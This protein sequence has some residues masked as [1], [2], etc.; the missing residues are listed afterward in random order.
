[1]G[2][3]MVQFDTFMVISYLLSMCCDQQYA[4]IHKLNC[5]LNKKL[6]NRPTLRPM[7]YANIGAQNAFHI[8]EFHNMLKAREYRVGDGAIR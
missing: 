5:Q 1:M 3:V 8:Y 4:T 2:S 6:G 7:R